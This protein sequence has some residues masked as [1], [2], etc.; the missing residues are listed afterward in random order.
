MTLRLPAVLYEL[1]EMTLS[2][3]S[4]ILNIFPGGGAGDEIF[5]SKKY[6]LKN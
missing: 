5:E 4:K 6:V 1:S 2:S 3:K